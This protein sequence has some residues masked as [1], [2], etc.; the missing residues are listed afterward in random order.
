MSGTAL[1]QAAEALMASP[2][3][4]LAEVKAQ[5][6]ERALLDFQIQLD[7]ARRNAAHDMARIDE[8]ISLVDHKAERC[9]RLELENAELVMKVASLRADVELMLGARC[10]TTEG[11]AV[12][13]ESLRVD[14]ESIAEVAE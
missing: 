6:R 12:V 1:Q 7:A 9:A 8:L 14:L 11:A 10:T 3:A 5:L 4:V 2:A 13:D